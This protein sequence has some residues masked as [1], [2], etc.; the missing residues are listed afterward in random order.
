MSFLEKIRRYCAYQE[1][2][3]SEVRRKLRELKCPPDEAEEILVALIAG[4]FLNEERFAR[5]FA[6]GK[7]NILG[8]GR[9]RIKQEL[10]RRGIS[11]RL[12]DESIAAEISEDQYFASIKKLAAR[13]FK[14]L[15][16]RKLAANMKTQ[17]IVSWLR[18]KGYDSTEIGKLFEE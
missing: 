11:D 3:H 1:R 6:R 7:H 15:S 9:I 12:I 14:S 10:N 4:N 18:S 13:K 8:W 17:K 16:G 5:S 2:C